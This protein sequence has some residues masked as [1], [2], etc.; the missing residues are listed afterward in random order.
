MT[1]VTLT[2]ID[3]DLAL[4]AVK[5]RRTDTGG[6]ESCALA[7]AAVLT[8][9]PQTRVFVDL[10]VSPF[11]LR[12]ADTFIRIDQVSA[13]GVV[14]AGG[15]QTLVIF[16][17]TVQTMVAWDAETPVAVAHAA[18]DPMS[19]GVEGA[20]V[21]ELSTGG[22]SEAGGAAAAEAQRPRALGVTRPI[23]MARTGRTWVHL[24]LTCGALET[25]G[26]VA[27]GPGQAAE[28]CGSVLAG[29]GE[30]VVHQELATLAFETWGTG[31][32][33]VASLAPLPHIGAGGVVSTRPVV[34]GVELL[35]EDP[36]V[37]VVT[38]AEERALRGLCDAAAFPRALWVAE[39]AAGLHTAAGLH[40]QVQTQ[41]DLRGCGGAHTQH[42]EEVVLSQWQQQV[43]QHQSV[44]RLEEGQSAAVQDGG[45]EETFFTD[46]PQHWSSTGIHQHFDGRLL[47][48]LQGQSEG[49][50][51]QLTQLWAQT[52]EALSHPV[53]LPGHHQQPLSLLGLPWR[54]SGRG[55]RGGGGGGDGGWLQGLS[56]CCGRR[57]DR[58]GRFGG[59]GGAWFPV[60]RREVQQDL[61]APRAL[62][63]VAAVTGEGRLAS[64]AGGSAAVAMETGAAGTRVCEEL[65]VVSSVSRAAGAG[66]LPG[67]A[68]DY[69][70][71][72]SVQA[73]QALA[74]VRARCG[75]RGHGFGR[76]RGVRSQ[77]ER[78]AQSAPR[79]EQKEERP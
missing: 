32:A 16:L 61:I 54:Q 22:A 3:I 37:A 47:W 13:G 19:T 18:A 72:P 51:R 30:A 42:T 7:A 65:T 24:L 52:V 74:G 6:V 70:A 31:A 69:Q 38:V 9:H 20:E 4:L 56:G 79:E 12:G 50:R 36:G 77:L 40:R 25:F 63:A 76:S 49:S 21:D 53:R 11:K 39:A 73:G 35:A 23:V 2:L 28:T 41:R 48:D 17:L 78:R 14:L 43:G 55:R 45:A 58:G 75:A 26:T 57:G 66:V 10:T 33:E 29:P 62:V 27:P 15:G 68:A 8:A 44:C 71:G 46:T 1:G 34:A 59:G 5:S 64:L 60:G 67:V